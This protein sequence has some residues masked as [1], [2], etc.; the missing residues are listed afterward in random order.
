MRPAKRGLGSPELN[1]LNA[2]RCYQYAKLWNNLGNKYCFVKGKTSNQIFN[3]YIHSITPKQ[4]TSLWSLSPHHC[5]CGQHSSFEAP[6]G[7]SP[8]QHALPLDE[9][10]GLSETYI[11]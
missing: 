8:R 10:A 6:P 9:L 5:A 11:K 1:G 2:D 7:P 4:V 3:N